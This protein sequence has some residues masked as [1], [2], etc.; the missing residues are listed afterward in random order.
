MDKNI[1]AL[2]PM[3][4]HSER[5]HGKNY[6]SFAGRPL[7]HHII[8]SLLKCPYISGIVIDTDSLTIKEDAIANFPNIKIVDRPLHLKNGSIS[9]NEV[10]LYD[11]DRVK[12]DFYLQTHST[13]PLLKT[14]TITRAIE[15]FFGYFPLYDSLFSVTPFQKRLWSKEGEAINHN[16]DVLLRTQDLPLLYEE[17][18]SIYI[19]SRDSIKKRHNRIGKKPMMFEIDYL[20]AWDI[21]NEIDF[22]I[23][24]FL[25]LKQQEIID[26]EKE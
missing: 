18:S 26:R 5:I 15:E 25:Y 14:M 9:M 10:L 2:V 24:E 7:Y 21:D 20:E 22:Q 8:G 17:N 23:A 13:N 3:R 19:F 12:A 1:L 11:I 6:R 4:H 16:P